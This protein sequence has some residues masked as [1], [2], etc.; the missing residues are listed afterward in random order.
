MSRTPRGVSNL[1]SSLISRIEARTHGQVRDLNVE[2]DP[3]QV[4]IT[5]KARTH[6]AKQ[7]AQHGVMDLIQERAI[8]NRIIVG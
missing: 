4:V 1:A 8:I 7:L 6:Y 3:E 5:G 2:L